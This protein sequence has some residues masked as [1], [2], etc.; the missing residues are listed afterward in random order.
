MLHRRRRR[1]L[2]VLQVLQ[3]LRAVVM[4]V[5]V[6][7]LLL[8]TLLVRQQLVL[9]SLRHEQPRV[10]VRVRVGRRI[11]VPQRPPGGRGRRCT[12]T[13]AGMRGRTV[14]RLVRRVR[15]RVVIVVV[16][17]VVVVLHGG[18]VVRSASRSDASND[19][20]AGARPSLSRRAF[21]PY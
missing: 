16:V 12:G 17:V 4:L 15:P 14:R 20:D 11:V 1:K 7:L 19:R 2:G 8:V 6:L 21:F 9:L 10:A 5:L 3:V 18:N 13:A